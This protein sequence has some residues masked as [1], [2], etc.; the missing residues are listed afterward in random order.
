[1][2]NTN[3]SKIQKSLLIVSKCRPVGSI[4]WFCGVGKTKSEMEILFDCENKGN[5]VLFTPRNTLLYQHEE[6]YLKGK[7]NYYIINCDNDIDNIE[8][9]GKKEKYIFLVN[10]SSFEKF[11]EFVLKKKIQ[12][13]VCVIDEAHTCSENIIKDKFF[14][15]IERR[16][17][18]TA[19]PNEKYTKE[20]PILSKVSYVEALDMKRTTQFKLC[21]LPSSIKKEEEYIDTLIN[22]MNE[23]KMKKCIV[24]LNNVNQNEN[25]FYVK[26]FESFSKREDFEIFNIHSE[27]S[28]DNI[29]EKFKKSKK[30]ILFS[31]NTISYG[32]DIPEC[33]CVVMDNPGNSISKNIQQLSRCLRVLEGKD[34]SYVFIRFDDVDIK[35]LLKDINKDDENLLELKEQIKDSKYSKIICIA[36]ILQQGLELDILNDYPPKKNKKNKKEC[37]EESGIEKEEEEDSGIEK[38]EEE[39]SGKEEEEEEDSGK[40]EEEEEESEELFNDKVVKDIIKEIPDTEE[41]KELIN[42]LKSVENTMGEIHKSYGS[43]KERKR[44]LRDFF[45]DYEVCIQFENKI[46]VINIVMNGEISMERV[47]RWFLENP[48]KVP[49]AGMKSTDEEKFV[50]SFLN[51]V[52]NGRKNQ[53]HYEECKKLCPLFFEKYVKKDPEENI[54]KLR[55]WRE[56]TPDK[57]Y[58]Q[59]KEEKKL[60]NFLNGVRSGTKNQIH[61]EECKKLCPLYFEGYVKK[62]E[63]KVGGISKKLNSWK[64]SI[65][66][67]KK[68]LTKTSKDKEKIEKL[69]DN[70]NEYIKQNP[71]IS[72]EDFKKWFDEVKKNV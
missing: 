46:G 34:L 31:C 42:E 39:D 30:A 21:F 10:N 11:K 28:N 16:Y 35:K 15:N 19:T 36:N 50:N 12:I 57:D 32:I 23:L 71:D 25:N 9:K 56:E 43:K 3:I 4:N 27:N 70:V 26:S 60:Y 66:F 24:Y 8:W 18:Y 13:G 69:Q 37:N 58:P 48:N 47:R 55:K 33:D 20:Y 45:E 7:D 67:K 62:E 2:E 29:L 41:N 52:R 64:F 61:Y 65:N 40:E 59:N 5:G 51:D 72:R 6:N 1:M 44:H 63:K 17:L 14:K 53:I 38:E 49:S 22:K 68:F 54:K